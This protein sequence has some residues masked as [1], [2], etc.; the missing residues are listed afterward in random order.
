MT[1]GRSTYI[2]IFDIRYNSSKIDN[3]ARFLTADNQVVLTVR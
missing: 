1:A 2:K 3:G